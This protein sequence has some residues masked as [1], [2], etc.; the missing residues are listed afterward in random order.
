MDEFLQAFSGLDLLDINLIYKRLTTTWLCIRPEGSSRLIDGISLVG[1]DYSVLRVNGRR[2]GAI[3]ATGDL[4][5]F[6]LSY[7]S[8]RA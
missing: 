5:V 3:R 1:L 6:S 4:C 2:L 8:S 7:I